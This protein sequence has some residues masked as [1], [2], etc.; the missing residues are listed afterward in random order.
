MLTALLSGASALSLGAR[1]PDSRLTHPLARRSIASHQKL[2]WQV[3][4]AWELA[5]V[6]SEPSYIL[7]NLEN[8]QKLSPVMISKT[9][10][11]ES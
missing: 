2:A 1:L 10:Q 8:L 7:I 9:D 4:S 5:L 6:A 11:V 3:G